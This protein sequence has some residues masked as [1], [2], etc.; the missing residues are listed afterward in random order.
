M[1]AAAA[2]RQRCGARRRDGRPCQALATASGLCIAH[3]PQ[4]AVW[5][6][7][8]GAATSTANR[9]A[10]LLPSRLRPIVEGLERAFLAVEN[11]LMDPRRALAM[12]GVASALVRCVQTGELE[13]RMRAIEAAAQR[14]VQLRLQEGA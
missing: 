4:A 3:D 5:R 10:K 12:A 1:S 2:T 13:E 14:E 6:R 8:G 7:A 9:A 11:G